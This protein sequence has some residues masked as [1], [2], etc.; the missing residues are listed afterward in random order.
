[1]RDFGLPELS[2]EQM[3]QLCNVT[4][5]AAREYILSK[6]SKREAEK[7]DVIVEAEG[8]KPIDLRVEIDLALSSKSRKIDSAAIVNEAIEKAFRAGEDFLS[9]LA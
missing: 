6:I 9:K 1:M 2:N 4:E 8:I 5:E 7:L 3:E